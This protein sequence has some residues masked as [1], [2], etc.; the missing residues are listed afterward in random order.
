M[1]KGTT[2]R[3]PMADGLRQGNGEGDHGEGWPKGMA[4]LGQGNGEG[5]H[6]EGAHG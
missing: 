4:G 3:E 2:E 5:D 1:G 6:G